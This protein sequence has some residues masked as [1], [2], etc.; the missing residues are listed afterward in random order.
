MRKQKLGSI[1][2]LINNAGIA[3]GAPK[4]FWEQ[5]LKDLYKV[6]GTNVL[7]LINV[8]H[9]VLKSFLIP[10]GKGDVL[11]ISRL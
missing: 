7:G 2:I 1:D 8:T 3:L 6:V 9:A 4:T 11:N 5:P 10:A